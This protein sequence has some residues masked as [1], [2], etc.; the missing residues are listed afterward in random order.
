MEI[1]RAVLN[2]PSFAMPGRDGWLAFAM[3][4]KHHL[5][6]AAQRRD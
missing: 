1:F 4:V 3:S 2:N 6:A 5:S